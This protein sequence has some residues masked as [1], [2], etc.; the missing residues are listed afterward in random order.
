MIPAPFLERL[1]ALSRQYDFS[2]FFLMAAN[3]AAESLHADGAAFIVHEGNSLRYLFFHGLPDSYNS[4]SQHVFSDD[5]G[6]S[7]EAFH[8]DT[9]I[10]APDYPNSIWAM[11]EYVGTGLRGSVA[12]PVHGPEGC[13][14]ILAVSWFRSAPSQL[15][16][17]ELHLA[18]LL[19]DMLG[20]AWYRMRIESD[21]E[22]IA[23]SDSLTGIHNRYQLEERIAAA[24]AR[25]QHKEALLAVIL[26]DLDGF[27]AIND[28]MGHQAGD[29]LLREI[30][31]RLQDVVRPGDTLVRYAGDEFILLAEDL[32]RVREIEELMTRIM[33]ALKIRMGL[34]E[35]RISVSVSAG[36]SVYPLDEGSPEELLH[37]A[38]LALYRA[39]NEGGNSW[40]IYDQNE[41]QSALERQRLRSEL[42]RALQA[43]EFL[44]YWQPIISLR[45]GRCVGAEALL[46][47]QHPSNGL[48]LPGTFLE[49]AEDSPIMQRI[50]QWVMKTACRQG[51]IWHA[52]GMDLDIHINLAARQVEN[53]RLC[54]DLR[55]TLSDCPALPPA[56]VC[57]ELVE[58][59]ALRDIQKT[60][61]MIADCR[62]IGVHFA[63]DDFGTGPAALQYLLELDCNQIKIDH[64]FVIPM[65]HSRRHRRMVQAMLQMAQALEVTVTAEG[66]EDE[67]TRCLLR[68]LGA[69]QGQGFGIGK[70]MPVESFNSYLRGS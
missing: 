34:H 3:L 9:A 45:T 26:L 42:D 43:S 51:E 13:S 68:E 60:A 38:D 63:L 22:R 8:Q 37:H 28:A 67:E 59:I 41:D 44:L 18:E 70:P 64:S 20:A 31:S 15:P 39:K 56:K 46:R 7:G 61:R 4:L 58:R 27:K 33:T 25:A 14:G 11:P 65:A 5:E 32:R 50:G 2:A 29:R 47:W 23:T 66:I 69:E 52:A 19:A 48:L 21:L 17:S 24:C 54:D 40:R 1:R 55:S 49:V 12:I 16:D 6:I 62:G 35:Q 36:V 53:H 10:Y 57:L 30:V